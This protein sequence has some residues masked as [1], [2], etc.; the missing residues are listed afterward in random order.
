MC[1][2]VIH[3]VLLLENYA[4]KAKLLSNLWKQFTNS[5]TFGQLK[6]VHKTHLMTNWVRG[7]GTFNPSTSGLFLLETI[8]ASAIVWSNTLF[9]ICL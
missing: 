9:V 1:H 2:K 6:S 5:S 3:F 7:K 8:S 4:I